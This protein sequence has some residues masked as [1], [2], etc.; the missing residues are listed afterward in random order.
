VA[1]FIVIAMIGLVLPVF[2]S[3]PPP[4]GVVRAVTSSAEVR[5]EYGISSGVFGPSTHQAYPFPDNSWI[6]Y[7]Y[8]T[9]SPN[10]PALNY[11]SAE[12]NV[13]AVPSAYSSSG[14]TT[15]DYL[16]TGLQNSANPTGTNYWILQPVLMFGK[17]PCMKTDYGS[18]WLLSTYHLYGTSSGQLQP[19]CSTPIVAPPGAEISATISGTS[20][21]N[22]NGSC[23]WAMSASVIVNGQTTGTTTLNQ[24]M[25]GLAA[26]YAVAT[27][28]A[29]NI[30]ECSEYPLGPIAF[31]NMLIYGYNGKETQLTPSW[32]ETVTYSDCYQNV[33]LINSASVTLLINRGSGCVAWGTLILTPTGDVR[34]QNLKVGQALEEYNFSSGSMTVG[35]LLS[36]NAT[37]ATGLID[38]NNGWLF[39]TPTDQPIYI[40]NATFTGWLRDS[41]NLTVGDQMFDP[42]TGAWISVRSVTLVQGHFLVYDVVTSNPDNF[43]ANGALLDRK[44]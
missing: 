21:N 10:D 39:V 25:N 40:H 44:P 2:V 20:C 24:G 17:D 34:V 35:T 23:N 15:T 33:E 6:E 27:L 41:Q 7:A 14:S 12:W 4:T 29:W 37:N 42:V 11:F 3:A 22:A 36:A 28:E 1:F 9:Y 32:G 5:G 31:S 19:A 30:T 26:H 18:N 13:P 16:F 43:V 38:I 8:W